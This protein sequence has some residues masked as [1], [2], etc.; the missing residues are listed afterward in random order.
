[1]EKEIQAKHRE[2][3]VRGSQYLLCEIYVEIGVWRIYKIDYNHKKCKPFSATLRSMH[4]SYGWSNYGP[5]WKG[6]LLRCLSV[7]VHA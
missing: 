1:M 7:V 6:V 2:E 4:L 5:P 3:H